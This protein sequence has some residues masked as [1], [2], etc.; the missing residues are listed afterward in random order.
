MKN[1]IKKVTASIGLS[2]TFINFCNSK[3]INC[4]NSRLDFVLP[5]YVTSAG[6]TIYGWDLGK[7]RNYRIFDVFN[8]LMFNN[9]DKSTF[10][11]YFSANKYEQIKNSHDNYVKNNT[12]VTIIFIVETTYFTKEIPFE[13]YFDKDLFITKPSSIS[14][15]KPTVVL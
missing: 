12:A 3:N 1:D 5:K 13:I 2:G 15:D 10:Y 14:F 6:S 7:N 8:E 4:S 11:T 9:Y